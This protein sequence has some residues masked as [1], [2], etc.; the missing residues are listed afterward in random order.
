MYRSDVFHGWKLSPIVGEINNKKASIIFELYNRKSNVRYSIG[1][2]D[3]Q[4]TVDIEQ[5]GPTKT[6]IQFKDFG[7]YKINWF[8]DG[9]LHFEHK[10]AIFD[11]TDKLIF[12]SCDLLEADTKHSLWNKM[13][14]ELSA[15]NQKTTIIH[16]GDQVY[17]DPAFNQCKKMYQK[18][19]KES[20]G[21]NELKRICFNIYS[22][23]Y[24]ATWMP[25][26]NLLANVSNFYIWDD[27]E[28]TNDIRLDNPADDATQYISHIA[29]QAYN[30]Y[31]QSFHVN[32][33]YII[34]KYCWYKYI[35]SKCRTVVLAIER[36]SREIELQEIFDTIIHLDKIRAINRLI[37]CFSSAP[38]PPPNGFYGL[39]Y[40]SMAG[41]GKFWDH[42]KLEKLFVWLFDWIKNRE[43]VITGGDVH[44]GVHGY[45]T[46]A[47][48]KIQIL[49][50]SP[51]TNQ[52][53][54]DRILA[55]KGMYGNHI[56]SKS[57]CIQFTTISSKA[58]RCYGTIDLNTV[59][60]DTKIVY[61]KDNYPKDPLKYFNIIS[62]F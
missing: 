51:I 47:E 37:L 29:Q 15:P 41:L 58:K 10:V 54:I 4:Y 61:S 48:S 22:Q 27:H 23:R 14:S 40:K 9:D 19:T 52:P 21:V 44:Y 49:I 42:D 32:E 43:I 35:D 1:Q 26:A 11:D 5:I 28:I 55:S 59:P 30:M 12:V 60:M 50:C 25:H 7:N 33:T 20:I 6:I 46:M 62:K 45:V 17:M 13:L 34:N 56:I 2:S 18:I 36:T 3:V 16:L 53:H 39:I 57:N 8:I 24:C 38:I 31:Q